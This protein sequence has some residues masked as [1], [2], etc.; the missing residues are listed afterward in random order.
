MAFFDI[1]S[2]VIPGIFLVIGLRM[3][4]SIGERRDIDVLRDLKDYQRCI[5]GNESTLRAHS[6]MVP[7][8]SLFSPILLCTLIA[9]V[10]T[11][12]I[13]AQPS[14]GRLLAT[15]V[16][17]FAIGTLLNGSAA[18]RA[19]EKAKSAIDYFLPI[20]ME[21]I[22]MAVESGLDIVPAIEAVISLKE[23]SGEEPD[24]VTE[25]LAKIP[26]YSS[27]GLGFLEAI[28]L[29]NKEISSPSLKHAL[30][31][32]GIAYREGGEIIHPL[33]ELSDATQ[34]YFQESVEEE[35]AKMP[36]KATVP[37]LCTFAGLII[38]FLTTPLIQVI[39][40]TSKAMPQ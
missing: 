2:L 36:V 21:R 40:I 14:M 13:S 10:S 12:L 16:I 3:L 38:S 1:I 11:N 25:T 28:N 4:S 7:R 39:S 24:P 35:I 8:Q 32:L 5:V 20:V 22:V 17:G 37:L 9:V 31:H 30:V 23:D 33:R 26:H 34:L 15:L 6:M 19:K 18:R 29:L 27:A